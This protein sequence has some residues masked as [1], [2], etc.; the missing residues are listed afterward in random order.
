MF[1][2]WGIRNVKFKVMI[3]YPIILNPL[4]GCLSPTL[5]PDYKYTE[6]CNLGQK[7]VEVIE[8]AKHKQ[9]T[10]HFVRAVAT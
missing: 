8:E 2:V 3:P 6:P 5:N 9:R 1:L 7:T 4:A 10:D